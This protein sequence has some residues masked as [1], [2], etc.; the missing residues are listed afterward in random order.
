[1]LVLIVFG[2]NVFL[3][4]TFV[5]PKVQYYG[6]GRCYDKHGLAR[7]H[8]NACSVFIQIKTIVLTKCHVYTVVNME[9]Y[10]KRIRTQD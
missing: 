9:N 7:Y 10:P 3:Y 5:F 2:I 1:M 4:N 8:L 6:Y